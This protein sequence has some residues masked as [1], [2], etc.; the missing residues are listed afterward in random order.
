MLAELCHLGYE[1]RDSYEATRQLV[2]CNAVATL[3]FPDMPDFLARL[4]YSASDT[5]IVLVLETVLAEIQVGL[6]DGVSPS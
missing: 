1:F 3:A 2:A 4:C 6:N 5:V